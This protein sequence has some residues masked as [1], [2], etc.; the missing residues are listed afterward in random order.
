MEQIDTNLMFFVKTTIK[1]PSTA[2]PFYE[3]SQ[4]GRDGKKV[5]EKIKPGGINFLSPLLITRVG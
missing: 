3:D 4:S 2:I 5:I 1:F